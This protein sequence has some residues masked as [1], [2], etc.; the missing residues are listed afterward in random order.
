MK[1]SDILEDGMIVHTL[2]FRSVGDGG[3]AWYIISEN[4]TANEMDVITCGSLFANLVISKDIITPEMFGAY[5]NGVND[6]ESALNRMFDLVKSNGYKTILTKK[7]GIK[8]TISMYGNVEMTGT[9]EIID[10]SDS[11]LSAGILYH[12]ENLVDTNW[13]KV[14]IN[15][16][17]NYNGNEK[18]SDGVKIGYVSSANLYILSKYCTTSCIVTGIQNSGSQESKFFLTAYG[19]PTGGTDYGVYH[20]NADQ[21]L[22]QVETRDCKIGLYCNVY[23]VC[24]YIHSWLGEDYPSATDTCV[25][26]SVN[27][28]NF[29]TVYMDSV[30]HGFEFE[31]SHTYNI[32][33]LVQ[34]TNTTYFPDGISDIFHFYSSTSGKRFINLGNCLSNLNKDKTVSTSKQAWIFASDGVFINLGIYQNDTMSQM[35]YDTVSDVPINIE[36]RF[37]IGNTSNYCDPKNNGAILTKEYSVGNAI[38]KKKWASWSSEPTNGVFLGGIEQVTNL[39]SIPSEGEYYFSPTATNIPS[40]WGSNQYGIIKR[41]VFGSYTLDLCLR[42]LGISIRVNNTTWHDVTLS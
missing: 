22:V 15:A 28:G 34:Y 36:S 39:N 2:G 25:V 4:G 7:Y 21:R 37:R 8:D 23:T 18:S 24:D 40:G 29:G 10:I 12:P 31:G 14:N 30:Q 16:Y 20:N 38:F 11:G 13:Y 33:S 6:D 19:I 27:D 32:G 3:S 35:Q 5:G 9:S 41:F 42:Q 1:V 26:H 17:I